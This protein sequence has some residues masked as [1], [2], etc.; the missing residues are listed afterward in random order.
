MEKLSFFRTFETH[1]HTHTHTY[2]HTKLAKKHEELNSFYTKM[3]GENN[4]WYNEEEREYWKEKKAQRKWMTF[5]SGLR[6]GVSVTG[7]M[8]K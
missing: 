6:E 1:T 3:W 7:R 8:F 5:I 4:N 2:T